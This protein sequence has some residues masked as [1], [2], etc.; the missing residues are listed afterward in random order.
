MQIPKKILI[1]KI[2]EGVAKKIMNPRKKKKLKKIKRLTIKLKLFYQL[3]NF[4]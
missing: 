1:K 4:I 2:R 3:L